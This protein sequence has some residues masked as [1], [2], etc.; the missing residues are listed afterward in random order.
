LGWRLLSSVREPTTC[1]SA[2]QPAPG[3]PG[4][5]SICRHGVAWYTYRLGGALLARLSR[6]DGWDLTAVL[7][8]AIDE[9]AADHRGT[10]D[11]TNPSSPQATVAIARLRGS[12]LDY[13]LLADCFLVLRTIRVR[14]S[15]SLNQNWVF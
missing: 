14:R 3:I 7:A 15:G 2:W 8:E 10:C 6:D 9:I 13:L 12:L 11:I 1:T 4:T 5:E